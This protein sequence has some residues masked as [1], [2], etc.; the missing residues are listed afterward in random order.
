MRRV[1]N[2]RERSSRILNQNRSVYL[3]E[4]NEMK[5]NQSFNRWCYAGCVALCTALFIGGASADSATWFEFPVNLYGYGGDILEAVSAP[6]SANSSSPGDW[7]IAAAKSY[8]VKD[9]YGIREY[10][11]I[12]T[13]DK[14]H[15]N[16]IY[17]YGASPRMNTIAATAYL[18][19]A[20][21]AN[22][23]P[24]YTQWTSWA[25]YMTAQSYLIC[26]NN[27]T[28]SSPMD[29]NSSGRGTPPG[30]EGNVY[31]GYVATNTCPDGSAPVT[32][33][34]HYTHGIRDANQSG[35]VLITK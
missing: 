20:V 33:A 7:P 25:V 27:Y 4:G 12:N 10:V 6:V 19:D 18:T 13:A 22:I 2:H 28:F 23:D 35:I 15:E 32:A 9:R 5:V 17:G 16:F 21:T 1:R 14:V 3:Q 31:E 11:T 26:S 34:A 8:Y 24:R 29:S 30:G